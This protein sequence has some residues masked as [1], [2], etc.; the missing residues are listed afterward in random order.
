MTRA[1]V[2][3]IVG[4]IAASLSCAAPAP[5]IPEQSALHSEWLGGGGEVQP[6]CVLGCLDPDPDPNA[7]GYFLPGYENQWTAC[8]DWSVDLDD[9]GLDDNCEYKLALTFRPL[10]STGIGDDVRR[11]PRWAAMWLDDD[12]S[13]KTVRIAYLPSYWI[14]LGLPTGPILLACQ[15]MGGGTKCGNHS[16]DSEWLTLDVKYYD[17]IKHWALVDAHFSAH[18]WHVPF[19]LTSDT[20]LLTNST[21]DNGGDG[22]FPALMTYPDKKGGYPRVYVADRK[23]ANYPTDSYCD[24]HGA[25]VLGQRTDFDECD[26]QRNEVRIE[27]AANGNIGSRSTPFIDCVVTARTDHPNYGGGRTECYW[28]V[29]QF[30]GWLLGGVPADPYSNHLL[31]YMGF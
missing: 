16:G 17:S 22:W 18:D 23:H 6:M 1:R 13:T 25:I 19:V 30:Q 14:D 12:P 27:V 26:S 21:H 8:A 28:T 2:F 31:N 20:T 5:T 15:L 9:D 11:E 10:L 24:S 4:V 7:A 3:L 29:K